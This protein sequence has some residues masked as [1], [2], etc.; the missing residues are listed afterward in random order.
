MH[1]SIAFLIIADVQLLGIHLASS[2]GYSQYLSRSRGEKSG[3]GLVPMGRTKFTTSGAHDVI[4]ITSPQKNDLCT[5]ELRDRAQVMNMM[6][7]PGHWTR[8]VY[9]LE[10]L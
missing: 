5:E 9:H 2:A 3:E 6:K 8:S 10:E 7:L 1:G 4:A